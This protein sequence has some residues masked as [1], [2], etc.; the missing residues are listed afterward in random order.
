MFGTKREIKE[1]RTLQVGWAESFCT[2]V[3]PT[4]DELQKMGIDIEEEPEYT[5]EKDGVDMARI[6]FWMEEVK[7]GYKYKRVFFLENTV[8]ETK[9]REG[10]DEDEFVKKV[11]YINQVG[12]SAWAENKKD[13]PERFTKFRRKDK[14]NEGEYE[15]YGEKVFRVAKRG[16]GDLMNFIKMW[17]SGLDYYDVETNILL[18]LKKIFNGNF[19]EIKEQ[20]NGEFTTLD[21]GGVEKPSTIVDLLE[22]KTIEGEDGP[23]EYQS[24]W[25]RPVAGWHIKAIR[26]TKFS[27][28]NIA[29]WLK[30]GKS[31]INPKGVRWLKDYEKVAVEI[32]TGEYK[33]KNFYSL[34]LM[35]E[36]NSSE[37]FVAKQG[38]VA[39]E[40]EAAQDD[41][42]EY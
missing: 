16:E 30:E 2:S 27:K 21:F 12:D 9:P 25:R 36:Y 20:V 34:E 1:G 6:E 40:K 38:T 33:S 39:G 32:S 15:I 26:N 4:L 22:V 18:D 11:Q 29:K 14:K 24:V 41:D 7:T 28:E 17:M 3:N 5:K 35:H 13:L 10:D 19:K 31:K 23:K 8:S 37:N 42:D